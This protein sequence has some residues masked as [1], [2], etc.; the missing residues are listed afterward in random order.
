MN[1]KLL[2]LFQRNSAMV[3]RPKIPVLLQEPRE[4]LALLPRLA[5]ENAAKS[6]QLDG[7]LRVRGKEVE[8]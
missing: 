6:W 1:M 8:L 7:V 5:R 3:M 2:E 4:C